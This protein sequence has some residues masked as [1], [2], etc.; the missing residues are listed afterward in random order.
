MY[1][2]LNLP[3]SSD[4]VYHILYTGKNLREHIC[5]IELQ[6][7]QTL[8]TVLKAVIN[9]VAIFNHPACFCLFLLLMAPKI[10]TDL[11]WHWQQPIMMTSGWKISM[12]IEENN[13]NKQGGR[14]LKTVDY[15]PQYGNYIH[16]ALHLSKFA[17]ILFLKVC[18]LHLSSIRQ[19]KKGLNCSHK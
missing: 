11:L 19:Q 7:K 13:Q 16:K 3:P 14:K 12:I 10:L 2:S 17:F 1:L 6:V 18:T 5:I 15:C 4:L 8:Y 9:M